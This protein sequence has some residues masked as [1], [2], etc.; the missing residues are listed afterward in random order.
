MKPL[1][2]RQGHVLELQRH[3]RLPAHH[4]IVG[5]TNYRRRHV[6]PAGQRCVTAL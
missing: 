3:R 1:L 6:M 4:F 5:I 2:R